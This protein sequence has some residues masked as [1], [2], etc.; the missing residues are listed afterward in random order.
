LKNQGVFTISDIRFTIDEEMNSEELKTR[1][2]K[3][4]V[5]IVKLSYQLKVR[6][7][8]KIFTSQLIRCAS[9]VGAN[10]RAAC[11]VKSDA[12]YINKL[13]IVEEETD[14]SIFFLELIK[15]FSPE[16]SKEVNILN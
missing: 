15:E 2:K 3:F 4:A 11:R 14:E 13:K 10:Y 1:T 9:S 7:E 5:D 16:K 8:T 12:D 6:Q